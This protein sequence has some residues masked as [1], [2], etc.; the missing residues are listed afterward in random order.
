M[1][2]S[3][4]W[5]AALA[6]AMILCSCGVRTESL[7]STGRPAQSAQTTG[8]VARFKVELPGAKDN[9]M[10]VHL[11]DGSLAF[12]VKRLGPGTDRL[13]TPDEFANL[14]YR[15]RTNGGWLES[16]F[17]I[18]SPIG[19]AWVTLGLLGQLVFTARML[20]Q[21]I[22]SERSGRSVIPVAFWW[23]SLGGAVMLVI[24]FVWRRDIVGV[25]GQ[26]TGLFV[27][28]RNLVLIRRS[29]GA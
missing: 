1:L 23:L 12:I 27:Y 8:P 14:L 24:Y 28:A 6:A 19:F 4:K 20:V 7:D 15:T 9:V 22:A 5:L 21:W 25:L 3:W 29:R 26:A 10:L 17:N 2:E 11:K 16:I 18:T 13:L